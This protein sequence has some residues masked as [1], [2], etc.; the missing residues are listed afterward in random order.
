[1][2]R[3]WLHQNLAARPTKPSSSTANTSCTA[4]AVDSTDEVFQ[5]SWGGKEVED[6]CRKIYGDDFKTVE[7]YKSSKGEV[8]WPTGADVLSCATPV[9]MAIFTA[10]HRTKRE[11]IR[12]EPVLAINSALRSTLPEG[13]RH[14]ESIWSV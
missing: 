13:L 7:D 9:A 5:V 6:Y 2:V 1:M 4:E 14:N 11:G 8:E 12:H 10:M 3:T